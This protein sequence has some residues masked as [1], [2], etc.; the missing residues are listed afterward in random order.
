M[1]ALIHRDTPREQGPDAVS[2]QL[3]GQIDDGPPEPVDHPERYLTPVQTAKYLSLSV[4]QL[5]QMRMRRE[6]PSW[7]RI[8]R[9]VRYDVRELDRWMASLA[10]N[11]THDGGDP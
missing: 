8:G 1:L 4:S 7:I 9:A 2:H 10:V 5:A 11:T 6:G 3:I